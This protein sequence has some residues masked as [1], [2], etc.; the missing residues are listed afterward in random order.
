M[1]YSI[2]QYACKLGYTL[3]FR[4]RAWGLD[5]VPRRGGA[6]LASNHQSFMDPTLVGTPLRRQAYYMTRRTLFDVPVLGWLIRAVNGFPVD[7][8]GVDRAAVRTAVDILARG[9]ILLVFPEGTRTPDGEIKAF[10]PGFTMLASQAGVPIVPAAVY[11][12]YEAWPRQ[13]V[14]PHPGHVHVAYG[15]PVPPPGPGRASRREAAALVQERIVAL[16]EAL[17]E[18]EQPASPVLR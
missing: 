7:R 17:R 4:Y 5:H 15:A 9:H 1:V 18:K 11:G 10:R 14:F 8:G 13:Q 3:F 2:V 6:L 12:A 16:Q